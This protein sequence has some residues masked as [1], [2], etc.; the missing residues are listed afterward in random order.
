MS[1]PGGNVWEKVLL[2]SR[3]PYR[4]Y[5]LSTPGFGDLKFIDTIKIHIRATELYRNWNDN[6]AFEEHQRRQT[7]YDLLKVVSV[8]AFVFEFIKMIKFMNSNI[9]ID[10]F[11]I[12]SFVV[13]LWIQ[14]KLIQ[15]ALCDKPL[16]MI[17]YIV[18]IQLTFCTKD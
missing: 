1:S 5:F 10:I 7:T 9:F 17:T 13:Y 8:V 14:E 4:W 18:V 6:F 12:L 11:F 2:V 15:S 3:Q 16:N